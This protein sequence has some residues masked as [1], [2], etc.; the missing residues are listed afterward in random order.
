[1]GDKRVPIHHPLRFKQ[2]PLE[3]AGTVAYSIY[4]IHPPQSNIAPK[5]KPFRT[6]TIQYLIE[7]KT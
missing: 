7:K 4:Y 5:K 6:K 2:H 1:M 3:G